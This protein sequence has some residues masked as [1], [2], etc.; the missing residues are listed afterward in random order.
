MVLLELLTLA[1]Q[2]VHHDGLAQG[3]SGR[4]VGL[5]S[6]NFTHLLDELNQVRV[7]SQHEGVDENTGFSAGRHLLEGFFQDKGVQSP[8]K[9][10]ILFSYNLMN[11]TGFQVGD[12]IEIELRN[13]QETEISS[14]KIGELIMKKLK[15]LDKVAY[16][17]FASVY[18]D[19][20]DI[21]EFEKELHKLLK[22]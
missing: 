22:K 10:E 2:K 5:S 19:F 8:G 21:E 1:F 9:N 14:K 3:H 4:E 13:M 15:K 11:N 12:E 17:R 20:A 16:I 7:P 6:G 18:K